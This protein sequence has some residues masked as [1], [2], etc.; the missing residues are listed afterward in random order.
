MLGAAHIWGLVGFGFGVVMGIG[1]GLIRLGM[2]TERLKTMSNDMQ[3][4]KTSVEAL[5][6]E[7]AEIRASLRA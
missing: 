6:D 3:Q 7:L 4:M 2:L 5:R 1:G